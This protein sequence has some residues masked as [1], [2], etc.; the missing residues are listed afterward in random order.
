MRTVDRGKLPVSA[1]DELYAL[2]VNVGRLFQFADLLRGFHRGGVGAVGCGLEAVDV[3]LGSS[4][5]G[6]GIGGGIGGLLGRGSS[7]FGSSVS[8]SRGCGLNALE[9]VDLSLLRCDFF[10]QP[11]TA[12]ASEGEVSAKK[13]KKTNVIRIKKLDQRK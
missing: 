3:G 13:S 11:A 9:L 12:M 4:S 7:G 10:F 2:V 6:I 5:P 8:G 1:R